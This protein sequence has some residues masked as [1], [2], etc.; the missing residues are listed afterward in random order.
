MGAI[1]GLLVVGLNLPSIVVTLA[2]MVIW[3]ESL[4]WKQQGQFIRELPANFQWLGL[5]QDLGQWV[6][7]AVAL[8]VFALFAW[9]LKYLAAGRAVYATGS[10]AEAARLAGIRPRRVVF[11]VFLLMGVL[12][13]L[14]AM[15]GTMR[16]PSVQPNAGEGLELQVIAAVVVGG[17]AIT[18]GR[19]TLV[20]ALLGVVLLG[21]S[22]RAA[23][24]SRRRCVLGKG[25][26][27]FHHSGIRCLDRVQG[28]HR[29]D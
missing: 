18:G 4:N 27:G 15:L 5:G 20:G 21:R 23:H 25:D 26:R 14:S 7:V 29:R 19:G 8:L 16:F 10:D 6:I 3:R 13:G 1:N 22:V 17:V 24:V 9:A 11:G 2:T 12:V 28:R